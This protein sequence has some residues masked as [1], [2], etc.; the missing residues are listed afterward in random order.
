MAKALC[1]AGYEVTVIS[2]M[3]PHE[4][5][6]RQTPNVRYIELG[7]N[8]L[9]RLPAKVLWHAFS[10]SALFLPTLQPLL[11]NKWNEPVDSRWRPNWLVPETFNFFRGTTR[12][13]AVRDLLKGDA[14]VTCHSSQSN[15]QSGDR[16]AQII[17]SIPGDR[18]QSTI[19]VLQRHLELDVRFA[20]TAHWATSEL[21]FNFV[22]AH[23]YMSL[24][25]ADFLARRHG[26][27]LVYD[28]VEISEARNE[29]SIDPRVVVKDRIYRTIEE[30]L[31]QCAK[32]H[33]TVGTK[34]AD[35]YVERFGINRPIVV[36]N[37]REYIMPPKE[38]RLRDQ[39]GLG[40]DTPL[41]VW[42][43]YCYPSQGLD[44]MLRVLVEISPRVHLALITEFTPGWK[45]YERD[46]KQRIF[47][48]GLTGRIAFL[49]MRPP[50]DL[51]TYL[52]SA[53][54]GLI[55]NPP[56][57]SL[58]IKYSLPN[59]FFELVM[60]R[61]PIACTDLPEI[62]RFLTCYDIGC[63]IDD[64][65]PWV[66]AQAIETL[67]ARARG[68]ELAERSEMAAKVLSWGNEAKALVGLYDKLSRRV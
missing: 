11:Y 16:I 36:K 46:F 65:D 66:A 51:I 63:C 10:Q 21:S 62:Q 23:D 61:L 3:S 49:P 12:I 56:D 31:V 35:W 22:Q 58:N 17:R 52:S 39:L 60:A 43:G 13:P 30:G 42:M 64:E 50:N 38:R 54:V 33:T 34:L 4:E 5:L 55:L 28:A 37:C 44:F 53:D 32:A 59:K 68:G 15:S 45:D 14:K 48:A 47:D 8:Q 67:L 24:V 7:A 29:Q 41:L 27:R 9:R 25:A 57:S 18:Y 19:K 2:R 40:D 6:R 26:A 1:Q 20:A